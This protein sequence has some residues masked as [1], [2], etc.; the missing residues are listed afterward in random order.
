M[1]VS[2][3]IARERLVKNA[4][5]ASE[6]DTP[7]SSSGHTYNNNGGGANNSKN[8]GLIG[9]RGTDPAIHSI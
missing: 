8:G 3:A 6:G 5:T 7:P 1:R 2:M 4:M 9:K